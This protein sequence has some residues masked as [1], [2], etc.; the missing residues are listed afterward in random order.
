MYPTVPAGMVTSSPSGIITTSQSRSKVQGW[1]VWE[2]IVSN[3][4][5]CR[6]IS[7]AA[8]HQLMK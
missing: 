5:V 3:N 8:A 4:A 2:N 7:Q 6:V 1:L